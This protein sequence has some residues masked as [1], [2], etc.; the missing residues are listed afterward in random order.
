[1]LC[2]DLFKFRL[3]EVFLIGS[4]IGECFEVDA[5]ATTIAHRSP[6]FCSHSCSNAYS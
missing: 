5:A 2:V 4:R 6:V 3:F 1:M